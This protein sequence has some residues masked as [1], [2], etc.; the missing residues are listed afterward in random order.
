M[1]RSGKSLEPD[2]NTLLAALPTRELNLLVPHLERTKLTFGRT[3]YE[4]EQAIKHVY[5]PTSGIISLVLV[6]EKGLIAEVGRVGSEG[7][8]GLPVFFG[9]K[10]SHTRAFVQLSGEALRMP[11]KEFLRQARNRSPLG[12]VLLRY[13]QALMAHSERLTACNTRH[14]IEERL[15]RWLLLTQDR[16]QAEVI[17]VTQEFLSQMLGAHRQSVTLAARNLQRAGLI[18]YRRGKLRIL[19]RQRLE[20]ASCG[21]Y[22]AIQRHFDEL[23]A[24]IDA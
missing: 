24:S 15:C 3:L 5:F 13:A 16:V 8:I 7:M 9:V 12:S 18:R 1:A 14:T 4:P 10:A 17:E 6:L 21:C 11:S 2:E 20:Q 23:L 19:D 22:L